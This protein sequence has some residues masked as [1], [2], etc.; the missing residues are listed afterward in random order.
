ML[1]PKASKWEPFFKIRTEQNVKLSHMKFNKKMQR[2]RKF[3]ASYQIKSA[4]L[5]FY[6]EIMIISPLKTIEMNEMIPVK[7]HL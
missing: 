6:F 7:I 2:C 3:Q 4:F 1:P 5:Y